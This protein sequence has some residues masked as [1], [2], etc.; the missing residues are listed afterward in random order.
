MEGNLS[1]HSIDLIIKEINSFYNFHLSLKN[2][3]FQDTFNKGKYIELYIIPKTWINEW[4]KYTEYNKIKEY[5][6]KNNKK[7]INKT[8]FLKICKCAQ[9]LYL[10][11][12]YSIKE[13]YADYKNYDL[14][15]ICLIDE[16][17]FKYFTFKEKRNDAKKCPGLYKKNKLLVYL[18]NNSYYIID[19]SN[20]NKKRFLLNFDEN[21]RKIS[22]VIQE[23][24]NTDNLDNFFNPSK[25]N[26]NKNDSNNRIIDYNN[27]IF[28]FD[29]IFKKKK[30]QNQQIEKNK[31]KTKEKHSNKNH[32]N[33]NQ[34]KNYNQNYNIN[35]I[36][37][38]GL[39]NIN[40]TCYM[41]AVLQCFSHIKPLTDYLFKPKV[42][43]K[44]EE[45]KNSKILS[46]E[47]L[48]LIKHLWLLDK[49]NLEYYGEN[50]SY[51]PYQF[52]ETLG[53]LNNQF[54]K[55]EAND[56]KDLIIYI[57]EQLHNEL[58]F[59]EENKTINNYNNVIINQYNDSEV[60]YNFF[61]FFQENYNSIISNL[62]Y[63]SQRT[64]TQCLNCKSKL[65]NYQIYSNLIFPLETIR[66]YKNKQ[67]CGK[68]TYVTF[69]D[70]LDQ[71]QQFFYFTG[72][73]R[74]S[75]NKCKSLTD[76]YYY[77]NLITAPN[78]LIIILNRGKG[79]EF[80]VNLDIT[81]YI[82]IRKYVDKSISPYLFELIGA[83]IHYGNSGQDGHF[84]AICKNNNEWFK[85]NDSITNKTDF[86][87]IKTIGIPYV[88]FYQKS[89]LL[90]K[91]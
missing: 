26:Y 11:D 3:L 41:N 19:F 56:S 53:K 75:C 57:E 31:I 25:L 80:N 45:N 5:L 85:Y 58:N 84:I 59:L 9:S 60:R 61:K 14:N 39:T 78:I 69:E 71:F 1:E 40:S 10:P 20:N 27:Q 23:I 36:S 32:V 63:G 30:I 49:N 28:I 65:Y 55:N 44:I 35:S 82:D 47:Y 86:N 17:C 8:E 51:S 38:V 29:E 18:D 70:C 66:I 6:R 2:Q 42:V 83:I 77:N 34:D 62:F 91:S 24:I 68:T 33:K 74:I 48:Q 72:V 46:F 13:I 76:A 37:L 87:E 73:N 15:K 64:I 4:K 79:L 22:C 52:K 12:I 16:N 90:S 50:K 81:E 21:N 7:E 54:A 43:K 88:L 89:N 67:N